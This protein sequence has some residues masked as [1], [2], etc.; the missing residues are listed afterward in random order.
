M[1]DTEPVQPKSNSWLYYACAACIM[2]TVSLSGISELTHEVGPFAIFYQTVGPLIVSTIYNLYFCV[3][4]YRKPGGKFWN[5]QNFVVNG[6]FILINF[7]SFV[8][9][10]VLAFLNQNLN[11]LTVWTARLAEVNPG[12]VTV[13]WSATPIFQAIIDKLFFYESLKY[14]HWIGM[15]MI[16]ICSV[17]LGLQNQIYDAIYGPRI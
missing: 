11:N 12:V 17:L 15:I 1:S 5:D 14:N 2:I 13:I 8:L 9:F 7:L 16:I 10:S 3:L 4:N 6:R